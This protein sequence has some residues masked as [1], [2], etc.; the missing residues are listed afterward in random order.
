MAPPQRFRPMDASSLFYSTATNLVADDTN[1]VTDIFVRDLQTGTTERV[2]S[3]AGFQGN[4]DSF[5]P[6]LSADGR[7]V[8]FTSDAT[9]LAPGDTNGVRDVFVHSLAP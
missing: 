9:N 4:G 2:V 8:A 3:S 7:F 5:Y 6:A 1:G